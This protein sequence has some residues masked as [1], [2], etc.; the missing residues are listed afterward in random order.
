MAIDTTA[1]RSRRALLS[2]ALGG[3]AAGAFA[4]VSRATPVQALHDPFQLGHGN[5]TIQSSSLTINSKPAAGYGL[6]IDAAGSTDALVSRALIGTGVT[7]LTNS[8]TAL[9][10]GATTGHAIHTTGGRIRI[11]EVSGVATIPKGRKSVVVT[12]G[13]DVN[14]D[15]F[16]LLTPRAN[17][18]SRAL[19]FTT[20]PIPNKFMIRMSAT[21]NAPTK[22]AWLALE[23]A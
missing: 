15:T 12:P 4:S 23:T 6:Y 11:A 22:V 2:A 1:P 7:G 5:P 8:G 16:V 13:V 20:N 9:K 21:R 19:W 18:G 10:A 14:S 3:L 17:I